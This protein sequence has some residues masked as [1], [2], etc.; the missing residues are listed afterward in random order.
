[1]TLLKSI[2]EFSC[3]VYE[4]SALTVLGILKYDSE[5]DSFSMS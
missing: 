3:L 4:G 2:K 5:S 1:M